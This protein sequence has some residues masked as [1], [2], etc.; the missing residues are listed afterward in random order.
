MVED[1]KLDGLVAVAVYKVMVILAGKMLPQAGANIMTQYGL[2]RGLKAFGKHCAESV[3]AE[4]LQIHIENTF[5]LTKIED[6]MP[7]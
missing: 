1:N 4:L 5:T 7:D 2:K 3:Q 6:L